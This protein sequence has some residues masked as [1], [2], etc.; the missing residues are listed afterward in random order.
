MKPRAWELLGRKPYFNLD[1]IRVPYKTTREEIERRKLDENGRRNTEAGFGRDRT[2]TYAKGGADPGNVVAVSQTY[3]QH[4]G[5]AGEH[6]AVAL[7]FAAL[8]RHMQLHGPMPV[9]LDDVVLHSDP[10]RKTA[11]LEALA[12]LGSQTQVVTFTHDPQ[13]VA[14]AQNAIDPDRLT[15]HELGGTQIS[16]TLQ[17][18]IAAAD[19]RPIR[20]ADTRAA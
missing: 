11:I 12:D 17:P 2:K 5:P 6:T 20:P 9:V 3:N 4:Y 10:D 19:V 16:G 18:Q 1:A 8:E 15:V 14:L 13:V 7:R